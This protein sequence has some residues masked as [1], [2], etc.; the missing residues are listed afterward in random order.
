MVQAIPFFVLLLVFLAVHGH[1]EYERHL[2]RGHELLVYEQ[3]RDLKGAAGT[4][5]KSPKGNKS[6]EG[7]ADKAPTGNNKSPKSPNG[8]NQSQRSPK[9]KSPKGATNSAKGR[10]AL[11]SNDGT[12]DAN[13]NVL[14]LKGKASA[15]SA[16][17]S[18]ND[19]K[20]P[21]G[22]KTEKSPKDGKA[23]RVKGRAL[24]EENKEAHFFNTPRML[25]GKISTKSLKSKNPK[26]AKVSSKSK[27]SPKT[28]WKSPKSS[29]TKS[30]TADQSYPRCETYAFRAARC[31]DGL[32]ERAKERCS[33][34]MS[35]DDNAVT[36]YFGCSLTKEQFCRT[37]DSCEMC[38]ECRR[39][40]EKTASCFLK[41]AYQCYG[42][43]CGH[44]R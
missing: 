43:D 31:V 29:K 39:M 18:T 2:R 38:G 44:T 19:Q 21:K 25:K 42:M 15:K 28:S 13:R 27:G 3:K 1:G 16:K 40:L 34:C 7:S 4:S 12:V 11:R 35:L 32:S 41:Q 17:S 20:S 36:D 37:I 23:K 10:G 26:S 33:R 8:A 24:Q 6:P 5:A 30:T 9:G 14:D 22:K